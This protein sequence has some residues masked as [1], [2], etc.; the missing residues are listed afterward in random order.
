MELPKA[1]PDFRDAFSPQQEKLQAAREEL[2]LNKA[3]W[4]ALEMN[5]KAHM[6]HSWVSN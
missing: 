4:N 2:L 3:A 1:L 5:L 6:L